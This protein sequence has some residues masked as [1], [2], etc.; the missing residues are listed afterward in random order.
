METKMTL[1]TFFIFITETATTTITIFDP[2]QYVSATITQSSD[3][4]ADIDFTYPDGYPPL[5]ASIFRRHSSKLIPLPV[6]L[7]NV[8]ASL[9][10]FQE[11]ETNISVMMNNN[12]GQPYTLTFDYYG[13]YDIE[14]HFSYLMY[15]KIENHK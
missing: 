10:S 4:S 7:C 5:V 11:I 8:E 2:L 13:E 1:K 3:L 12:D 6:L 14:I 15:K 9:E